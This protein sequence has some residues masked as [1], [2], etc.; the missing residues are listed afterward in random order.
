ML[1][2]DPQNIP[3][4]DMHQYLLG[5][6]APR[7]IAFASTVD[8][9]GNANIAPY[10]FFNAF[11]S[12]PPILVFSANR[13]VVDNTTKDT[14]SNIETTREVVINVVNHSIVRQMAVASIQF[15]T[16]VSEFAKSGLT[17]IPSDVVKPFRIKESPVQMECKVKDIITLG[18]E[19]GAGHLIIC[20]VVRMHIDENAIDNGRINPHKLDLVGRMGRAYYTRASGD[21]VFT[22]VQPVMKVSIGF[23]ALPESV[24]NSHVLSG[25]DLGILA[26]LHALPTAEE[27]EK[28]RENEAV[29]ALI[30]TCGDDKNALRTRLHHYA[31]TEIGKGNKELAM[32]VLSFS[33]KF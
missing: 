26:G 19:G 27:V 16:G 23:D 5:S 18:D 2:I 24:R 31:K 11:S 28:V 15:D 14:L 30:Q 1:T 10:S 29:K 8:A 32:S 22:V 21:A 4:R 7:P 13:R 9:D 3:T 6:V 25:N 12:N 17:P 20:N 33:D